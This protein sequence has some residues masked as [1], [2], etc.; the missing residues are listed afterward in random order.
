MARFVRA[1][2]STFAVTE[3]G[4]ADG[5]LA[6]LLHG[7][8]D[9]M[10]TWRHLQPKLAAAGYRAVAVAMRGYAPSAV[11]T[12][13][14]L[15]PATLPADVNALHR[16]LRGG[17]DAVVIG[18]DWGAI[19]ANR[20]A[21]AAPDR[22]RRVVT[23]AV[24]PEQVVGPA[25]RDGSQL[26]RSSYMLRAQLSGAERRLADPD[27][28][29]VRELWARWSPGYMMTDVD[30]R[31]LTACFTSPGVPRAA[32]SY[33]RGFA[34]A[35]LRGQA[36]SPRVSFPPQPHLLLHGQDDGCIAARWAHATMG[37]LPDPRSRVAVL[38]GV[39]HFLHLEAPDAVDGEVLAFLA[40]AAT[41]PS[42]A[43]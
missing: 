4:P 15:D 18:H 1:N 32:L 11:P 29:W 8:P 6:L 12:D 27:Q 33:Y 23:M 21:A 40:E 30:L 7:F 5:P 39:G 2:G 26:R 10:A 13:R 24:P 36:L 28:K 25:R 17:P 20:A 42:P 19:A 14:T 38:D 43:G 22:W 16:A 31:P 37:R 3:Q 41:A 9:T 35:V 34:L